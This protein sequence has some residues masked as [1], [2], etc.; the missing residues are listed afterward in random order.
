[1]DCGYNIHTERTAVTVLDTELIKHKK[2]K[3]KTYDTIAAANY[4]K[5]NYDT[6]A[7]RMCYRRKFHRQD[8][9]GRF[10]DGARTTGVQQSSYYLLI[11]L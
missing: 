7:E 11:I 9:S 2:K 6:D 4:R 3:K 8:E 1:M 10:T 5:N